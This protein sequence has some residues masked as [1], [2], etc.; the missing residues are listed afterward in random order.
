MLFTPP[1]ESLYSDLASYGN[2][3]EMEQQL[4]AAADRRKRTLSGAE[5]RA[6]KERKKE[7][8]RQKQT[9]WLFT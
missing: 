4:A 6:I 1:Q 5:L 8:K 2:P 7:I 9:A 3:W